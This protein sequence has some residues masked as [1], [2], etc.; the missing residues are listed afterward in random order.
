[1]CGFSGIYSNSFVASDE[2]LKLI[3][4]MNDTLAHRGPDA[5]GISISTNKNLILGHR[6]LSIIDLDKSLL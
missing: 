5:E 1:M 6:R 2:Y 4:K 3:N